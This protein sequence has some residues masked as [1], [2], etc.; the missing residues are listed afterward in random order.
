MEKLLQ[1]SDQFQ[2]QKKQAILSYLK[3]TPQSIPV[4]AYAFWKFE[5][6]NDFQFIKN[7]YSTIDKNTQQSFYGKAIENILNNEGD[8]DVGG[9]IKNFV[10]F[11]MNGKQIELAEEF[12]KNKL[13]LLEF[14]SSRCV[15]CRKENPNLVNLY[16]Q[17]HSKGFDIIAISVDD[18]EQNWKKA[19]EQ[20]QLAWTQICDFESWNGPI[21]KRYQV[22]ETPTNFLIN[23]QGKIVAKNIKGEMLKQSLQKA[24]N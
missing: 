22:T 9:V 15:P 8:I 23:A 14:W 6:S 19:I 2:Q 1:Q 13:L 3:K 16:Q 7:I 4:T 5:S 24:F 10:A 11:E 17:Y 21:P 20:D 12:K 18:D